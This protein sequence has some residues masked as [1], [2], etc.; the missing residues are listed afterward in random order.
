MSVALKSAILRDPNEMK[1]QLATV[2]FK[3][4]SIADTAFNFVE[5]CDLEIKNIKIYG[6]LNE[7]GVCEDPYFRVSDVLAYNKSLRDKKNSIKSV[8]KDKTISSVKN[9]AY[10]IATSMAGIIIII[11]VINIARRIFS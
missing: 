6:V 5:R 11:V 1:S 3:Q 10:D 9:I 4:V 2:G 7:D 8:F